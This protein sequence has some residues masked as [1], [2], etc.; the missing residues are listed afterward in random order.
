[1]TGRSLKLAVQYV[2]VQGIDS[3]REDTDLFEKL[4]RHR[5]VSDVSDG[6]YA[7]NTIVGANV[8][9]VAVTGGLVAVGSAD[10]SRVRTR[11]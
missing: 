6:A 11:T 9:H 5:G 2:S 1:V 8:E 4:L 3:D 7:L 10:P